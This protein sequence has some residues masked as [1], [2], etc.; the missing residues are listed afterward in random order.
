VVTF[1]NLEE[2]Y[3]IVGRFKG[4]TLQLTVTAKDRWYLPL[5][6]R[7]RHCCRGVGL[8]VIGVNLRLVIKIDAV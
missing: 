7:P 5:S 2:L 8:P 3:V 6:E 1:C 4:S